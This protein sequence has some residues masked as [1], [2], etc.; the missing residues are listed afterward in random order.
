M[1]PDTL[2]CTTTTTQV[3]FKQGRGTRKVINRGEGPEAPRSAVPR[4]EQPVE[5][6]ASTPFADR[7]GTFWCGA[8]ALGCGFPAAGGGCPTSSTDC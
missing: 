5:E 4:I 7:K 8:A 1:V 6:R 3:H 2:V